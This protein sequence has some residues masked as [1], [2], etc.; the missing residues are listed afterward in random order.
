MVK[1]SDLL[2]IL[3]FQL[4]RDIYF[5]M[6]MSLELLEMERDNGLKLEKLLNSAGFEDNE[7]FKSEDNFKLARKKVLD[8]YNSRLKEIEE[9]I[10][11]FNVDL[12]KK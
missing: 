2:D 5:L 7:I 11:K 12:V 1:L 9:L 6:K 8:E 4:R 10:Q 3:R